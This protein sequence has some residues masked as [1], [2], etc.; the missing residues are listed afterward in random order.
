MRHRLTVLDRH[1]LRLADVTDV[2]ATLRPSPVRP[3]P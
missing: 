3:R 1:G 2:I